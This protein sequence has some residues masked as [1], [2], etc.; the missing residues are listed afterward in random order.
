M[1]SGPE[2]II[3]VIA[4]HFGRRLPGVMRGLVVA[5]ENSVGISGEEEQALL[6]GIN[7]LLIQPSQQLTICWR[8]P[9]LRIQLKGR[10]RPKFLMNGRLFR[11]VR[12]L[13]GLWS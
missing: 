11:L 3:G 13:C 5:Y 4:Y 8:P 10:A 9:S 12:M 6:L 7:L 2:W 1:P